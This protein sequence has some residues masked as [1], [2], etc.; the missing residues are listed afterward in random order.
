MPIRK[1]RKS[2][3]H[4]RHI[5]G[6]MRCTDSL[7]N[8]PVI[9]LDAEKAGYE[10]KLKYVALCVPH[11][12]WRYYANIREAKDEINYP[13]FCTT[14]AKSLPDVP[15]FYK[16]IRVFMKKA[17]RMIDR[18]TRKGR[19]P[20]TL[21][22]SGGTKRIRVFFTDTNRFARPW[23]FI[24]RLTGDC[25]RPMTRGLPCPVARANLFNADYGVPK[26]PAGFPAHNS[27]TNGKRKRKTV[28]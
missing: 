21:D 5:K 1:G 3:K 20:R 8:Q 22:Y 10:P 24:D 13:D 9:I 14:C 15:T 4:F 19:K 11:G 12:N 2:G 6:F 26:T 23:V 27:W 7:L 18:N 28:S 25:L 17:Q 16:R